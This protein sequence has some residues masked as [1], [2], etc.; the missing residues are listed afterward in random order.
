MTNLE[1]ILA[2]IRASVDEYEGLDLNE[3]KTQAETLRTLTNNLFYLEAHRVDAYKK[4]HSVY[5]QSTS[6]TNA[7][8]ERE[9][10]M[11][12]QD[13]YLIRRV[14]TSGYRVVD[15]IRST[16]SVFKREG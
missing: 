7:G 13:L 3:T 16:I 6:T 2:T 10:D 8:K 5:F 11:Q 14:M 4:W 15:S 9:A 1:E 12:V